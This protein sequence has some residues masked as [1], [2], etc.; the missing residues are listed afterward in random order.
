MIGRG[1][2]GNNKRFSCIT[3]AG[4][5]FAIGVATEIVVEEPLVEVCNLVGNGLPGARFLDDFDNCGFTIFGERP[6]TAFAGA[7]DFV[8]LLG[9]LGLVGLVGLVGLLDLEVFADL[10]SFED[11]EVFDFFA[12]LMNFANLATTTP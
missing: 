4:P 3:G 10:T 9:L 2:G 7:T 12:C 5:R 6:L 1:G 8:G 11:F